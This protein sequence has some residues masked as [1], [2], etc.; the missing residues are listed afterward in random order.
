[1]L[2]DVL[3]NREEVY[4]TLLCVKCVWK[5]CTVFKS[6]FVFV[7][8]CVCVGYHAGGRVSLL[9]RG[10]THRSSYEC[11]EAAVR[12]WRCARECDCAAGNLLLIHSFHT[13]VYMKGVGTSV[14]ALQKLVFFLFFSSSLIYVHHARIP[15]HDARFSCVCM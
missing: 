6:V 2:Y 8:V 4:C 1:M 13:H 14:R 9:E 3:E 15:S 10:Y 11:A 7:C 5:Y 12:V